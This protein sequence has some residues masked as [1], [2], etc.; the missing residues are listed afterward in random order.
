MALRVPTRSLRNRD[1]LTSNDTFGSF[2]NAFVH[3]NISLINAA[4]HVLILKA[5]DIQS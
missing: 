2:S 5:I 4:S 1:P 3:L